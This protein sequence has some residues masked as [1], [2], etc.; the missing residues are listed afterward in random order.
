VVKEAEDGDLVRHGLALIA[1]G[2]YHMVLTTSNGCFA[3]AIRKGPKVCYQRPSVDVLFRSVA[4]VAAPAAMGV[5]LTG[6]GSDGAQGMKSLRD[7]GCTTIAQDEAT[8][9]VFGMPAAAIELGAASEIL[10]IDKIGA[11]IIRASMPAVAR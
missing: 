8:S 5:L 2:D 11:S 1:P 10:P 3:V 6:M 9:V 4:E 7:S